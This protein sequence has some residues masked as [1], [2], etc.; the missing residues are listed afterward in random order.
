MVKVMVKI[1]VKM[2][3]KIKVGLMVKAKV[4]VEVKE[5]SS[6]WQPSMMVL[7]SEVP[8]SLLRF[9]VAP[10]ASMLSRTALVRSAPSKQQ[11]TA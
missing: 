9:M 4:M 1:H 10:V 8:C 2:K 7:S 5:A 6:S 3:V 11:P